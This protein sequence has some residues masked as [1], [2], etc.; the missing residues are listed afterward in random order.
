MNNENEVNAAVEQLFHEQLN[1]DRRVGKDYKNYSCFSCGH[2]SEALG[3]CACDY[4]R[5]FGCVGLR[6]LCP[7]CRSAHKEVARFLTAMFKEK[8]VSYR[9]DARR[10]RAYR[11]LRDALETVAEKYSDPRASRLRSLLGQSADPRE[12]EPGDFQR[13]VL[14]AFSRAKFLDFKSLSK[15]IAEEE[16]IYSLGILR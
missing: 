7:Q 1:A 9:V 8:V 2:H 16:R 14:D 4:P 12:D 6:S 11:F 3:P 15:Q 13:A 5:E 10:A